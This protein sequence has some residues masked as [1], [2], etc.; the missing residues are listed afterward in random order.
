MVLRPVATDPTVGAFG[1]DVT[2]DVAALAAIGAVAEKAIGIT[3]AACN[4]IVDDTSNDIIRC[5]MVF[6]VFIK[7]PPCKKC[8]LC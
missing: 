2:V 8:K 7:N 4:T 6:L 3:A 5:L 1:L